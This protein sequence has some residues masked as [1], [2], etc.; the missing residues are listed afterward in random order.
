MHILLPFFCFFDQIFCNF[1]EIFVTV[2][3]LVANKLQNCFK[4]LP[5]YEK[6]KTTA[7][8]HVDVPVNMQRF[9]RIL[10]GSR[11]CDLRNN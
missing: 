6:E 8:L 5:V 7:L 11:G 2:L 9:N 3:N 4:Q 1:F 10:T